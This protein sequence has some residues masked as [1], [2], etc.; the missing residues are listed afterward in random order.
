MRLDRAY[1]QAFQDVGKHVQQ[2]AQLAILLTSLTQK[3]WRRFGV[4]GRASHE[5]VLGVTSS[6]SGCGDQ[7]VC[8]AELA[9]L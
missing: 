2:D 3:F 5:G 6:W 1:V 8:D 7:G 4:N 9:T